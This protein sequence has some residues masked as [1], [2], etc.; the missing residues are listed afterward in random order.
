[1]KREELLSALADLHQQA[2]EEHSHFY[3]ARLILA[4][5]GQIQADGWRIKTLREALNRASMI[6]DDGP[7][8]NDAPG[9]L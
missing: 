7:I 6:A 2:T 3:T 8:A 4:A 9:E 5:M 1:M